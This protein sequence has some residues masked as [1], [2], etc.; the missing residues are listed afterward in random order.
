[1]R[2]RILSA[3]AVLFLA[4]SAL[5]AGLAVATL[6]SAEP[7][8]AP[9]AAE[10]LPTAS[11]VVTTDA[12][13]PGDGAVPTH[14]LTDIRDMDVAPDGVIDPPDFEHV[15]RIHG[16]PDGPIWLAAHARSLGR[17]IAPGNAFLT[18][19]VGDRIEALGASWRVVERWSASKGDA[20]EQGPYSD[21]QAYSG[22][23]IIV[24]CL[25][26]EGGAALSNTWLVA[27]PIGAP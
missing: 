26:R 11:P 3:L 24:S 9:S 1:M 23:L 21:A 2:T 8:P 16:L 14:T 10:P 19:Q 7:L 17:G 4:A 5:F 27:E 13:Q 15:F 6:P 25:P 22:R 20:G 12:P 18:F